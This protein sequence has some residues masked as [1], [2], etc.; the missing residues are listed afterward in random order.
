MTYIIGLLVSFTVGILANLCTPWVQRHLAEHNPGRT[1]RRAER[2]K[3]E[4]KLI[5]DYR[6]GTNSGLVAYVARLIIMT[7]GNFAL[8]VLLNLAA[9]IQVTSNRP[10]VEAGGGVTAVAGWI[11][12]GVAIYTAMRFEL[13]CRRVYDFKSYKERATRELNQLSR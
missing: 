4:L 7:V 12:M 11:A 5:E 10:E 3:K 13:W 6:S 9:F 1:Q 8:A 2:I